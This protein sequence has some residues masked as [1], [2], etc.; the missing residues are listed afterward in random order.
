VSFAV[1]SGN[2]GNVLAGHIARRMGLPIHKLI[3]ATNEN[4]V[5]DDFFRTGIY[6]VR[7]SVETQETSS[8]SMD[9][10]KAS[11]FERFIFDL[12]GQDAAHT[13]QLFSDVEKKG[14]FD[15]SQDAA[16]KR[17]KEFGFVSGKSTHAHRLAVIRDVAHRYGQLIDTH[18]ADGIKVAREYLEP[19]IPM[20]VLETAQP[21]KFAQTIEEALERPCPRPAGFENIESLPKRFDELPADAAAMKRYISEHCQ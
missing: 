10:S 3:V 18:T 14:G 8:P 19:G 21:A 13:R 16:F 7:K 11:N 4:N 9:I 5:L 12:L 20:V 2:F 17:V 1:P 15:L 6:R